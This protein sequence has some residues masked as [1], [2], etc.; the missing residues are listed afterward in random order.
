MSTFPRQMLGVLALVLFDEKPEEP[1]GR[2]RLPATRIKSD[3]HA[4]LA[5]LSLVGASLRIRNRVAVWQFTL[6]AAAGLAAATAAM[7]TALRGARSMLPR[8]DAR[9]WARSMPPKLLRLGA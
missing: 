3:E 8:L 2:N 6:A 5:A 9:V 1:C 4:P 7:A